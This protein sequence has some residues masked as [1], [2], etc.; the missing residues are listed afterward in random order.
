VRDRG[1]DL[2]NVDKWRHLLVVQCKRFGDFRSLERVL[3]TSELSKIKTLSPHRYILATSASL[4]PQRKE[5]LLAILA[6]FCN[7]LATSLA[8]KISTISLIATARL[9]VATSTRLLDR[10]LHDGVFGHS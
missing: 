8:A 6:P 3:R 10:V 9:N 4:N 2:R 1:I 7:G 5:W